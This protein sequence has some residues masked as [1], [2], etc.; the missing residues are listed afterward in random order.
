MITL[1]KLLSAWPLWLLHGA[2]AALGWMVFLLSPIYR[3]R[4][5]ENTQ[6]AGLGWRQWLGAVGEAG[7]LAAELPRLWLGRPVP[8]QWDGAG[9]VE[10]ALAQGRGVI[11]LTP[12]MGCFEIAAQAYAQRF[13][14]A[15][16]PVTVL[17]RPP[18]QPWLRALV[19][20]SRQRPGLLTAPTSL[21]GVKQLIK[22]LKH[23]EAVALLPDQVP[24]Q[25]MGV[26][27]PFF[28]REAYTMTLSVR[29][30]QQ[31]GAC[32]LLTWGERLR[33]GRGYRVHVQPLALELPATLPDAVS[34]INHVMEM[35]VL[36]CP[37][38][39]LWGY[40]RYKTPRTLA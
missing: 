7:K 36:H 10:A 16:T 33:W 29:L 19:A 2:G 12:H 30:M 15:G 40:A 39:Y 23:G 28:G 24:P 6:L 21:S 26:M 1:F 27:A 35:L 5:L 37:Q 14:Q 31:T 9:L 34:A 13:G 18:R 4:F 25:G 3:Q 8:V 32:V 11:F 20:E 38:Q 22:A 17:Y